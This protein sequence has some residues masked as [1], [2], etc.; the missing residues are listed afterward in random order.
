M[1]IAQPCCR[2]FKYVAVTLLLPHLSSSPSLPHFNRLLCSLRSYPAKTLIR[3]TASL[4]RGSSMSESDNVPAAGAAAAAAVEVE[5]GAVVVTY[6]EP[7][8]E[9]F[10]F[11]RP[12]MYKEKLAGTV[13]A[14]DRHVFLCYK[15]R[16][17]W[18][19]QVEK[20]EFDTVPKLM[21]AAIRSRKSEIAVKTKV[22]TCE[23]RVE[24]GF[25]EGDVLIFPDLVKY[26]GLKESVVDGFVDDVLVNGKP[27]ASGLAESLA[28]SHIFV[29]AHGSRDK[30]CGV[31]GPVLIDKL[32]EDIEA[33]GLKD[34]VFVSGCS[35]IGGHKY[36]GNVIVYG[37]DSEGKVTGH[38]YGYV[39]PEDVPEILDQDIGKGEVIERL[40]RGQLGAPVE[41]ENAVAN[42][43]VVPNGEA[44]HEAKKPS[45]NGEE[46]TKVMTSTQ[47]VNKDTAPISCC[48]GV[49]GI[50]CCREV[51]TEPSE[52]TKKETAEKK[53]C[54]V[55]SKVTDWIQSLDQSD[56]LAGAAVVGAVATIAVAYSIYRRSGK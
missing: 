41:L 47:V 17:S 54:S 33:R 45:T 7:D 38:W 16:E 42:E 4:G 21:A 48:Q 44:A 14:Y 6:E 12:E 49:N 3:S 5:A 52:E 10:G 1:R 29:C 40:F 30:R 32:N 27:W 23:T 2:S 20:T 55:G 24:A 35:H 25:E 8:E 39:T 28:G 26:K 50:S 13:D 46:A 43:K 37:S 31:C 15:N 18:M 22:T 51:N 34:Q 9:K 19:P 53:N 11:S 36:A 56:I